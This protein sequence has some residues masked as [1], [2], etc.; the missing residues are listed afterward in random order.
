MLRPAPP[1]ATE[2]GLSAPQA[3]ES[4]CRSRPGPFE[5]K[6]LIFRTDAG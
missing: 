3:A 4:R 6:I 2:A 1:E 5:M